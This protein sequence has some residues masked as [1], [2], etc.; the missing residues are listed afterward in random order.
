[1]SNIL[2]KSSHIGPR[3]DYVDLLKTIGILGIIAAHVGSPQWIMMIRNFDVPL[4]VVM[5]GILSKGKSKSGWASYVFKRVKRLLIP[6]YVFLTFYFIA[7]HML[8]GGIQKK[9][10]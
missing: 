2:E 4:L 7:T 10:L 9:S 5:S 3:K 1:M 8:G 6:T